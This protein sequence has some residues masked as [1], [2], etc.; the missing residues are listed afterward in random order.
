MHVATKYD[1]KFENAGYPAY[2][3]EGL[4]G[5]L[6]EWAP[7]GDAGISGISCIGDGPDCDVWE[8]ERKNLDAIIGSLKKAD[9]DEV[10]KTFFDNC[11]R[12]EKEIE[13]CGYT[14][15]AEKEEILKTLEAIRKNSD[16]ANEFI[17]I[18]WF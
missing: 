5:V 11:H 13:K 12:T 8:T 6:D 7:T 16:P 4:A 3:R 14:R 9:P 15:Y 10:R 18:E 1:I 2:V 17:H